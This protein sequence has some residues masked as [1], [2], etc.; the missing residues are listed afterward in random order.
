[1]A[2]SQKGKLDRRK[3]VTTAGSGIVLAAAHSSARAQ[4]IRVPFDP[5]DPQHN[6]EAFIRITGSTED[7]EQCLMHNAARVFSAIGD[8]EIVK[9]LFDMEGFKARRCRRE[10]D[11]SYII[12][13]R[14]IFI[15]KDLETGE[16]LNE[17]DNPFTGE[18]N[19]VVHIFNDPVNHKI[20]TIFPRYYNPG[21]EER[22]VEP[23]PFVMPWSILGDEATFFFDTN[24]KWKNRLD[25]KTWKREST[26]EYIRV[27]ESEWFTAKLS[28]LENPDMKNIPYVGGWSRLGPWLP[29]MLMGRA[30]GHLRY[31]GKKTKLTSVD[32]LANP[33]RD[34]AKAHP[35]FVEAPMEWSEPNDSSFE[36]YA[37]TQTPA[38]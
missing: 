27:T 2:T 31:R 25:P 38:P 20:G 37:R 18:T 34:Y 15:Y 23:E 22:Y 10:P 19:R 7:N 16:I 11:G 36:A 33:L 1:M 30:E 9:P 32:E 4:T 17:W 14:E 5:T 12:L 26:G 3:F 24:T 21:T 29:W 6:L 13:Q 28:D 35:D 8:D